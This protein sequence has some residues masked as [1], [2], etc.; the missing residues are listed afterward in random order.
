MN[1]A[2]GGD[3]LKKLGNKNRIGF[4]RKH[5]YQFGGIFAAS[6]IG[7]Q[8]QHAKIRIRMPTFLDRY[9]KAQYQQVWEELYEADE[10]IYQE[11]LYRDA[12]AV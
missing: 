8:V 12:L 3:F 7:F 9:F 6:V 1:T 11:P 4:L 2:Q 5:F 10:A